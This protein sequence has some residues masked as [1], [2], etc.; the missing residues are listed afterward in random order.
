[1]GARRA[2]Y[3]EAG[4]GRGARP[5][6]HRPFGYQRLRLT[7]SWR[8]SSEVV[9]IR[10]L[11]WKPRWAITRLVNS[12]ARSTF[13]IS[14]APLVMRPRPAEPAEPTWARPE[15]TVL[16]NIESPIFSRP[17]SEERR[18]GKECRSRWS[19]YH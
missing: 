8:I 17:R 19:P 5:G 1:M 16:R 6:F 10:L 18:V 15:F 4:A 12:C 11:A 9:M 13:D 3:A 14:S 7:S 2:G